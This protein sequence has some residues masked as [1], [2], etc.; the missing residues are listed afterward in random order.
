MLHSYT[1]SQ[2]V[3]QIAAVS[4]LGSDDPALAHTARYKFTVRTAGIYL[5]SITIGEFECGH[6]VVLFMLCS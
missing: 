2:L 4:E 6:C 1:Y 3:K 5:V